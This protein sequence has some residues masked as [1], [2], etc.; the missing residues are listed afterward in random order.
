[1][2]RPVVPGQCVFVAVEC[3]FA[4]GDTIGDAPRDGAE[5][6]MSLHIAVE[7]VEAKHYIAV[8]AIAVRRVD[9]GHDRAVFG[10]LHDHAVL[11]PERV[12]LHRRPVRHV[13]ENFF[14]ERHHLLAL[15][16]GSGPAGWADPKR[17]RNGCG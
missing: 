12:K 2:I 9:F 15:S 4:V 3:E 6:R 8:V 13:A 5:K 11:V 14:V 1:M 16:A 7:I 10:D 17:E